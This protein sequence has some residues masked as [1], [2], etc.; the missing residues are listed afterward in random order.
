MLCLCCRR[1][2]YQPDF[3]KYSIEKAVEGTEE[4][5]VKFVC[6]FVSL[7]LGTPTSEVKQPG[8]DIGSKIPMFSHLRSKQIGWLQVLHGCQQL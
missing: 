7:L 5:D 4:K 6:C 2:K 3:K 8:V 1:D